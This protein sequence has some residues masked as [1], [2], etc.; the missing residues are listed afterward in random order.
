MTKSIR[1]LTV[2]DGCDA[3][4]SQAQAINDDLPEE[5]AIL[6]STRLVYIDDESQQV[7]HGD[8]LC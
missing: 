3:I 8:A 5:E 4:A 1:L 7:L 2:R 6:E